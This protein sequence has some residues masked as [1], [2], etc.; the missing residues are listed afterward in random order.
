[1]R[2]MTA[3]EA[4]KHFGQLL[5]DA[6]RAPVSVR[7]HGRPVAVVLSAE[8]Y[9]ELQRIKQAHLRA[10]IHEGLA[11]LD[12]GEG[13]SLDSESLARL[14]AEVKAEGRARWGPDDAD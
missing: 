10:E 2:V 13:A 6:R 7:K 12:R 11:Q 8:D 1:M 3:N 9:E 4:K 5:D 14:V